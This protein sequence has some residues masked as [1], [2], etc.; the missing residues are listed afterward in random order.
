MGSI[1]GWGRSPGGGHGNPLQY[2]GLGCKESD[3]TE[4]LS[5]KAIWS[6]PRGSDGKESAVQRTQVWSLGPEDRL[7]EEMATHSSILAWRIPWTEEPGPLWPMGLQRVG[8]N[9]SEL[10]CVHASSSDSTFSLTQASLEEH[11]YQLATFFKSLICVASGRY[12]FLVHERLKNN[13]FFFYLIFFF[14]FIFKLY[15]LY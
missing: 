10:A 5:L 12:Y 13:N 9:W 3:T 2:S 7:E 6:F 4:W 15:K 11:I 14:Y 8:D 1:P